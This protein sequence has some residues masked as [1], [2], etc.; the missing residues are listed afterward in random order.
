[1][2]FLTTVQINALLPVVV[3][4]TV[5]NKPSLAFLPQKCYDAIRYEMLF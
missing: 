3:I 1:M 2:Y 4:I 5:F